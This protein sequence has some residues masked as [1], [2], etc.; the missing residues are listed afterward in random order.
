MLVDL[1]PMTDVEDVAAG[2]ATSQDTDNVIIDETEINSP[3]V[4]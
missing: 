3:Q 4:E 1:V 2:T